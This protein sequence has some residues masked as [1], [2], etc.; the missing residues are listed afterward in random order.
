MYVLEGSLLLV[1]IG[2]CASM[3]IQSA[4]LLAAVAPFQYTVLVLG[5]ALV[6]AP[7][8]LQRTLPASPPSPRP[9]SSSSASASPP[10]P[11]PA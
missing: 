6:V 1:L 8:A 10:S 9:A 2:V 4:Q 5:G 3:Q 11:A 7:L